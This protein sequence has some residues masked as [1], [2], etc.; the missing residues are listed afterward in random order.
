MIVYFFI[1]NIFYIILGIYF[2]NKV[3]CLLDFLKFILY[4][5]V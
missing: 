3:E 1:E 4:V 2:Y 5:F